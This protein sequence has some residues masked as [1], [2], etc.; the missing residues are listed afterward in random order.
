MDNYA[1]THVKYSSILGFAIAA[2]IV[3]G[4]DGPVGLAMVSMAAIGYF[5]ASSDDWLDASRGHWIFWCIWW[6]LAVIIASPVAMALMAV[7]IVGPGN[8]KGFAFMILAVLFI[9]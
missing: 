5:S 1:S 4:S 8:Y 9:L 2:L 6:S 7:A 3:F